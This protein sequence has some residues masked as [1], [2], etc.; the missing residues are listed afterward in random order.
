MTAANFNTHH[1]QYNI[2]A[3]RLVAANIHK[4]V[5]IRRFGDNVERIV[6]GMMLVLHCIV[7]SAYLTPAKSIPAYSTKLSWRT[8][9]ATAN[10]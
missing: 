2:L 3:G 8:R 6:A 1:P 9:A 7:F 10:N 4:V 5:P